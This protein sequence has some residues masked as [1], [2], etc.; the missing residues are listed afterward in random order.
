MSE[1]K[2]TIRLPRHWRSMTED[3]WRGWRIRRRAAQLDRAKA[4]RPTAETMLELGR[5]LESPS[6]LPPKP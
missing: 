4:P 3:E 6:G 1:R 2:R 5:L